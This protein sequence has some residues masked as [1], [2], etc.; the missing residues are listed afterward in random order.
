[1]NSPLWRFFLLIV[2]L[3]SVLA[4]KKAKEADPKECEV[5]MNNLEQI[6]KLIPSDKKGDKAAIEKAITTHCTL[7]GFGSEWKPNPALTSPK[8]VK[9]CY[10]FE[11]IK[12][13]ISMPFS[14][15]MPKKKVCERLKK[16]NPE[17]CQVKYR[18]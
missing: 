10:I 18:K 11:P 17:V 2:L 9:M 6:D 16:E 3:T 4:A 7:S 15:G 8:D 5:C 1:M 12:K 14:M 13:S